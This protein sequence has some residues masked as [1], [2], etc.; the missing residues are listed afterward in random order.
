M[1][2]QTKHPILLTIVLALISCGEPQPPG[3][4]APSPFTITR[5]PGPGITLS[6]TTLEVSPDGTRRPIRVWDVL[7][8]VDVNYPLD[9]QQGA[10]VPVDARGRYRLA[11]VPDGRF[12]KISH[13]DTADVR[14]YRFCATNTVTSGD[15]VL[16]VPLFL[17]GAPVPGPTLSGQIF[18]VTAG[19]RVPVADAVVYFKSKGFGPDVMEITDNDGRYSMCGIP[20]LPGTLYMACDDHTPYSEA[21]E[22]RSDQVIDIDA[23]TFATCL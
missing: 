22:V 19:N 23:T 1:R 14:R 9:S 10:L 16:D 18:T 13:V 17:P 11:G 8:D 3:S 5:L 6:G 21:V 20:P 4:L 15:T 2:I 12:V 7:V